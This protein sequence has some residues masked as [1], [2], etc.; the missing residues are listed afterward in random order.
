ML[1]I[2]LLSSHRGEGGGLWFKNRCGETQAN[3][4]PS[5]N[6]P[7]SSNSQGKMVLY[8]PIWQQQCAPE[9]FGGGRLQPE[10]LGEDEGGGWGGW[11]GGT[12]HTAD[13]GE[14]KMDK[15]ARA[16][17]LQCAEVP[18]GGDKAQRTGGAFR[19]LKA[20]KADFL[21]WKVTISELVNQSQTTETSRTS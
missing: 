1:G 9:L 4:F 7:A 11:E 5:N 3:R 20:W 18:P 15:E 16:A 19:Q 8:S 13:G 6:S 10:L 14:T 21:H 12:F 17:H 2:R